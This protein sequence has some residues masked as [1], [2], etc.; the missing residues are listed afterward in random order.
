[1]AHEH[2]ITEKAE[3]YINKD[4]AQ[5]LTEAWT[6]AVNLLERFPEP[7]G[8]FQYQPDVFVSFSFRRV[9][10][11][12]REAMRKNGSSV[13][14]FGAQVTL[15]GFKEPYDDTVPFVRHCGA[16]ASELSMALNAALD[17]AD[18]ELKDAIIRIAKKREKQ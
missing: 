8:D 14:S 10:D 9:D 11:F 15:S 17:K 12:R 6:R 1:M 3:L 16:H 2:R 18:I 13:F 7:D 5:K 4:D